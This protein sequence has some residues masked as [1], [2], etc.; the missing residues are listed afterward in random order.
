MACHWKMYSL[1][2]DTAKAMVEK[3]WYVTLMTIPGWEGMRKWMMG[4]GKMALK[5]H[6]AESE[7]KTNNCYSSRKTTS[8]GYRGQKNVHSARKKISKNSMMHRHKRW[9]CSKEW[10]AAT[11]T[12]LHYLEFGTP[13]ER[14]PR[15]DD[16]P[17]PW[18]APG[19]DKEG[20]DGKVVAHWSI[21]VRK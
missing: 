5:K 21:V 12:V 10:S 6:W 8:S 18:R 16:T 4:H 20:L 14:R 1:C 15:R 9:K 17:R 11:K 7:G 19:G 13:W 2:C 3:R